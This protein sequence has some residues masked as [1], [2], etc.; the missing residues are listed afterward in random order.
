[1]LCPSCGLD[2]PSGFRFCGRCGAA[3]EE[4]APTREVRKVVTI[5]FCDLTGS[6]ALGDR[7]DPEAL[8]SILRGYYDQMRTILEQHGGTV[9]K[10]VGDAVMAVFGV[11]VA[12]ED[13]AMRAVRA[14]WQMRSA[15][16]M[17]GL[18]ARIGVNTGEV[19]TGEGDTLVTGDAVNVAAR[20]E[21]HA[22]PGEVLIGPA[23]CRL[24]GGAI[25][26]EPVQLDVKGKQTPIGAHLLLAV[27]PQAPGVARRL[28]T[29]LVGRT[30]ELSLLRQAFERAV[31]AQGCHLFTLLG[32]AGVG[33]SRLV[34]EMLKSID[35]AV[36]RGRCLDYGEGITYW[37]V[38]EVLKQLGPRADPTVEL[39]DRGTPT[40]NELFW[41]VRSRLEDSAA[42]RPLVVVFDD[43]HWGAPTF[44]DLVDHI[45]DL[46]REAPILLLCI[47]RPELLDIRPGWGGGKLNATTVLL[48]SLSAAESAEL[49]GSLDDPLGHDSL[50][51]QT[52]ERILNMAGGNPLYVEE[53]L[54]LAREGG[55]VQV[56][57]TI[58]ALLQA[59]LDQLGAGERAV[60]ERGAVEG[61]VFHGG[62]V[63]ELTSEPD[64][65]QA[66]KHL[67]GLVR[68]E[69]IRPAPATLTGDDA[70]RF[71]H[72][73]IRDAAYDSLPKQIRA[74]LH[75]R[76]ASWLDTLPTQLA[77][78]DEILGYHFE[79]A[80]RYQRELGEP[81]QAIE[82]R[83]AKRLGAAGAKALARA[84]A[85][86]AD[87]LLTRALD[88]LPPQHAERPGI[89]LDLLRAVEISWDLDRA[90]LLIGELEAS[91][92]PSSRMNG[93]LARLQYQLATT[94]QPIT[95]EAQNAADEALDA[96][97]RAGDHAGQA[98]AW[99]LLAEV[100][101]KR[102]HAAATL[103]AL[104]QAIEHAR[105]AGDTV[106]MIALCLHQIGPLK[107]G[108][109]PQATVRQ[110]L[111]EMRALAATSPRLEAAA[112]ILEAEIAAGAGCFDEA[113]ALYERSDAIAS[114][115]G[116]ALLRHLNRASLADIE[117]LDSRPDEAARLLRECYTVFG[118]FGETGFRSTIAATL[119]R[120]LYECGERD[121]AERFAIE[122]ETMGGADDVVN[123][124]YGRSVR[125]MVLADRDHPVAAEELGRSA[126][127][128]AQETDL[129]EVHAFAY[130]ALA[131]VL[132]QSGRSDEARPLIEQAIAS[133]DSRG[134]VCSSAKARELLRR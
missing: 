134:D 105:Q 80:A 119:A 106:A 41:A 116:L 94:S 91:T 120:A 98:R 129:P 23:T 65:E 33:K 99:T 114:Q 67:V 49:I 20:L 60:V 19:V 46:S 12:H 56:P 35:A 40:T 69:L 25:Q 68:K 37:P 110:R 43:I 47:A 126:L 85:P 132:R 61:E 66:R 21:Q 34:A 87:N 17:L 58:Q 74:Q 52:R 90:N 48:E 28:D 78:Q 10:F 3:L 18:T 59:R 130:L 7:T 100:H 63:R 51:P 15:I 36:V 50:S 89:V 6:T 83:A 31:T 11:P 81:N 133:H 70:Y 95:I 9:E 121:E 57:S 42:E 111:S 38:I 64:R 5:V 39:L 124:A 13:D 44:L 104:D 88:L 4:M 123:F 16:G 92:D 24:V 26:A 30:G 128:Y 8:R 125:A 77:E 117:L 2:T 54:A 96:F 115:L 108:P 76:F 1:M 93:R 22:P 27:D 84:D 62:T 127:G 97:Q 107:L 109:F 75:E 29:P 102:S 55:D 86:A 14:V 82:L 72:L 79:Q 53:M 73:L 122:G 32:S 71:R 103:A 131:H 45:A 118:E 112:L 113:R 101:W